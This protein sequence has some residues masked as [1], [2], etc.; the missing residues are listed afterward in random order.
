MIKNKNEND[1]KTIQQRK[2]YLWHYAEYVF[3]GN[4]VIFNDKYYGDNE[5]KGIEYH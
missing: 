5:L 1:A 3:A 2:K 4:I